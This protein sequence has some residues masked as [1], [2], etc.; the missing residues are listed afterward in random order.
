MSDRLTSVA[1]MSLQHIQDCLQTIVA[2]YYP[3]HANIHSFWFPNR[4]CGRLFLCVD[5]RGV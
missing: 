1:D 3:I 4:F 5:S 2:G